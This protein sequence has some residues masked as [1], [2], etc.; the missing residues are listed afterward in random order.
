LIVHAKQVLRNGTIAPATLIIVNGT[1]QSILP[2][3]PEITSKHVINVPDDS[4]LMPGVVDSHVHVNEP[5]RTEWEGFATATKSA[6][7][8]G[9]TTLAD[10]PLNSIP[11]TTTVPNL[12]TKINAAQGQCHCDV[13]FIGGLVKENS[14]TTDLN[15]LIDFGICGFKCFLIDS[16]VN[17][18]TFVN[19]AELRNGLARLKGTG[20]FL[21]FHAEL[22]LD[23]KEMEEEKAKLKELNE[24]PLKYETFL[25]S[26]P[27]NMENK[28]I[29]LVAK[30][31]GEFQVRCHI[32]H[33]SS[34]EALP[35]IRKAKAQ[36]FPL[37]VESCYHYLY[38][39]AESIPHAQ[40]KYKCCPP[41]REKE[42][43]DKLWEAL[44]EGTIDLVVSDHS[45]CTA[46][47]KSK[48]GGNYME[49]WGGIS[50]LQFGLS[51]LH[52]EAI[53][54]GCTLAD[55]SKWLSEKPAH[56][57]GLGHRKGK[58]EEGFDADFVVFNPKKEW[59]VET[60]DILHKNK[61]TPYE[62]HKLTGK[63]HATILRG[64]VIY[65]D[66]KFTE[67]KGHL[68]LTEKHKSRL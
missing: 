18:F 22:A 27:R 26:R 40:P 44:K 36:G 35:T 33:L 58:I 54:R 52:T 59:T 63:V 39:D 48:K 46:D 61:L 42:N 15:A 3:S 21:M 37:T 62:G 43:R 50:S 51:I 67:P 49:S 32:V 9:V 11:P 17:E 30:V 8:G 19:E 65:Q 20:S 57:I 28:A 38:F 53:R 23:D 64:N 45:P 60:T 12:I 34:S 10:M 47:L 41:I 16:G 14:N 55:I 7:F 2:F 25:H 4:V 31:C 5:G 66:G 29:E 56:L 24:D 13:R 6:V 68:I 1:I